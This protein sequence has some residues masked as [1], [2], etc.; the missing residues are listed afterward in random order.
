MSGRAPQKPPKNALKIRVESSAEE[1]QIFEWMTVG[2]GF[3]F[4]VPAQDEGDLFLSRDGRTLYGERFKIRIGREGDTPPIPSWDY[5][6]TPAGDEL[7]RK[8]F[9]YPIVRSLWDY[10]PGVATRIGL[11]PR[12]VTIRIGIGDDPQVEECPRCGGLEAVALYGE[13]GGSSFKVG[14][15]CGDCHRMETDR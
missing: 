2:N 10:A 9:A 7:T 11:P 5:Q 8:R 13:A 15:Y 1:Q 12:T 6:V 4:H 3:P 14:T